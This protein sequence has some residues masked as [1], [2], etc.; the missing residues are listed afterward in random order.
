MTFRGIVYPRE[1]ARH[2]N[3]MK[4]YSDVCGQLVATMES[5]IRKPSVTK[6]ELKSVKCF[7]DT[8]LLSGHLPVVFD[9]LY[10]GRKCAVACV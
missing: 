5:A 7:R 1:E 6:C 2:S 4:L 10:N 9:P 3:T 8:R